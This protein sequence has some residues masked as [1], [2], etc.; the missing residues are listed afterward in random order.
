M[1]I[2]METIAYDDRD[3]ASLQVEY[4]RKLAQNA[5]EI[6]YYEDCLE[7][8][9]RLPNTM[10]DEIDDIITTIDSLYEERNKLSDKYMKALRENK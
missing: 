3:N 10:Q 6:H 2:V 1:P 4:S 7:K 5:S 9:R 8:A